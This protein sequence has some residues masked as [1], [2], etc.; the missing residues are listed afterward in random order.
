MKKAIPQE[1]TN[2]KLSPMLKRVMK[3]V[4]L[5]EPINQMNPIFRRNGLQ[6]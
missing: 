1:Q 3:K 2:Q 4:I 6:S 5:Q